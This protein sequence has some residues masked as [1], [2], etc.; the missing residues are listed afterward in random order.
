MEALILVADLGRPYHVRADQRHAG[1]TGALSACLILI[2]RSIIGAG[3]SWRET[4]DQR[5]NH[6]RGMRSD[7]TLIVEPSF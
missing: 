4:D 6:T 1:R 2:A 7:P 5:E 3:E